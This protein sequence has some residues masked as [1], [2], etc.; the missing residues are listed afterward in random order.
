MFRA[1]SLPNAMAGV[2]YFLR[3]DFSKLS[4]ESA[5]VAL[6]HAFFS[7]SLGMGT[8]LT[9]GAY[10]QKNQSLGAAALAV[11]GG[12]LLYAL[13]AGLIIFSDDLRFRD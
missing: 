6:G 1:L 4:A 11:G 5:L 8:M 12:D 7:L 3:P 9:Y 13:V 10:V 2:E